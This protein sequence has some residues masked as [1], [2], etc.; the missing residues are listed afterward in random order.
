MHLSITRLLPFFLPTLTLATPAPPHPT[1]LPLVVWHG[2]GDNYASPGLTSLS[3]LYNLTFAPL[4]A[5]T[6]I[7]N[8]GPTPSADRTATFLGNL[9]TQTLIVCEQ[10]STHPLLRNAPAI[11]ALGFSQGGQ[12]LRGYI[13]RC[14]SPPVA[15]LLTFGS[16][17]NGIVEFYA[18]AEHDWV[19]WGARSLMRGNAWSDA[20]QGGVIPAQYFRGGV[21]TEEGWERYRKRS[22]WLADINQEGVGARNETYKKNLGALRRFVMWMFEED[23]TVVPKESSWWAEVGE[24]G[25][26]TQLRDGKLYQEDWLGLKGVDERGGLR[27]KTTPGKHMDLTDEIL[28]RAMR[29]AFEP[30][31]WKEGGDGERELEL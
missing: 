15:N 22:G 17:H 16:Q 5:Y 18:C 7:I 23:K 9:T 8:L 24:K 4:T 3:S 29:E 6:H 11:N 21:E 28:M 31:G 10:L 2:L 1:L 14:N 27:F 25:N 20:A 13:Q 26:V 30:E 19:C 12:F